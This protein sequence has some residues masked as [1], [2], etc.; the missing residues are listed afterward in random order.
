MIYLDNA[1]T[2]GFKP[3][4]VIESAC[5]VIKYLSV[6]PG[7]SGHRL[8]TT[9]AELVHGARK[10]LSE[11]FNNGS[12]ERVV[13]TKNCTEAINTAIFG[14]IKKGD[15][16]ITSIFEHNSVLRPLYTLEEKGIISLSIVSP[17]NGVR[18]TKNDILKNLNEKTSLV[19]INY[20]SNVTGETNEIKNIGKLLKDKKI[21]FMVDGAQA[22]GHLNID[23]INDNINVLTVAGHKGLY[24]ILGSGALIFDKNTQIDNTF[25][26]GTGTETFNKFQPSC[27][28]EKLEAGT[29]NLPA[30]CSM[31]EG[32]LALFG[33]VKYLGEETYK[34]TKYL[35]DELIKID[36]VKVYSS[37]NVSGVVAFS[38][39]DVPSVEIAD[40]LS[41][42]FDIAVRGGFHCA[43]LMHKFLKTEENGLVRASL[44]VHNKKRE[45]KTLIDAVN[46]ISKQ[47]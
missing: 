33:N 26:G 24:G 35:I 29:L 15:H 34:L 1:A 44:S 38:V 12:S 23:L 32:V 9:G 19:V 13:F 40:E 11:F 14:L 20:V 5:N 30:I 31:S 46:Y 37:P 2:S 25:S 28:P 8:S 10:N 36:K 7:R 22:C 45:L 41:T 27:Y 3:S 47:L 39:S 16:V 43:P 17:E 6:N 4:S 21:T 18:I 42:K